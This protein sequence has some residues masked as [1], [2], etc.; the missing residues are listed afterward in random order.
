VTTARQAREPSATLDDVKRLLWAVGLIV[1]VIAGLALMT[2]DYFGPRLALL[3]GLGIGGL[4]FVAFA[5][6]AAFSLVA[7]WLG[8]LFSARNR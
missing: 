5:L 8:E 2:R 1:L 6:I 4:V 7:T 3:V